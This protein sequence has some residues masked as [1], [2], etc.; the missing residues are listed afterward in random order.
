M[1]I[2]YLGTFSVSRYSDN[3][4]SNHYSYLVLTVRQISLSQ[5]IKFK[6][7]LVPER[8]I[9][10]HFLFVPVCLALSVSQIHTL[11]YFFQKN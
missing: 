6:V 10:K 2:R 5:F 9:V 7:R 8:T 1:C 3:T 11:F 4:Y